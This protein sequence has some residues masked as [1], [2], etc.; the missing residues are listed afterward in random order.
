LWDRGARGAPDER[1]EWSNNLRGQGERPQ[2]ASGPLNPLVHDWHY[3]K[4]VLR[5]ALV[6]ALE[7]GRLLRART[8]SA[9]RPTLEPEQTGVAISISAVTPWRRRIALARLDH[10]DADDYSLQRYA[11][12][13]G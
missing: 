13:T 8:W 4:H 9:G 10:L 7:R 2:S 1:D 5:M 12:V 6:E 3:A 11:I